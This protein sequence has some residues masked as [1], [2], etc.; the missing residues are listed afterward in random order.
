MPQEQSYEGREPHIDDGPMLSESE[1]E[2]GAEQEPFVAESESDEP[3]PVESAEEA[4]DEEGDEPGSESE[5]EE[6]AAPAVELD[7]ETQAAVAFARQMRSADGQLDFMIE[8]MTQ[9]GYSLDQ[10]ESILTHGDFSEEGAEEEEEEDLDR[11]VTARELREFREEQR[12]QQYAQQQQAVAVKAREAADSV[13]S[14]LTLNDK[15]LTAKQKG[16]VVQ[17]AD[18]HISDLSDLDEVRA[19]VQAG[20]ADF[21]ALLAESTRQT[22]ATKAKQKARVPS[23]LKGGTAG[24]ESEGEAANVDA[25]IARARKKLRAAGAI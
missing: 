6:E 8:S 7:E 9:L 15:P 3:D 13:L 10:I 22:V 5:E 18:A 17:Y 24:S 16:I 25:A 23:P 19:G 14:S 11:L 21:E 1:V 20:F 2:D 4:D 12:R